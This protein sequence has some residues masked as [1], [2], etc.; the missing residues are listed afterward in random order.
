[1]NQPLTLR[2]IANGYIVA[3]NGHEY[4]YAQ[5]PKVLETIG[6]HFKQTIY[7]KPRDV[8]ME[9][10]DVKYAR[11]L[12]NGEVQVLKRKTVGRH[13]DKLEEMQ[14]RFNYQGSFPGELNG[15]LITHWAPIERK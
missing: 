12:V 4:Y 6:N 10:F 1:L 8:V 13:P 7:N 9:W 11:P 2:Q 5:F 14:E 15:W 3:Y